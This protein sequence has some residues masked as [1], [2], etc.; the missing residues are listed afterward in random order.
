M[1]KK[2]LD[3]YLRLVYPI[4]AFRKG[5]EWAVWHT[6]FGRSAVA[7]YGKT[8]A[9]AV[10]MLNRDRRFFIRHL[11]EHNVDIPEPESDPYEEYSG[12]FVLRIPKEL[13]FRLAREAKRRGVSM[14]AHLKDL[15][16]ERDALDRRN[17]LECIFRSRTDD[18]A[19]IVREIHLEWIG[20]REDSTGKLQLDGADPFSQQEA[21]DQRQDLAK[22][23]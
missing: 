7:G 14:N 8:Q 11:Y 1:N 19:P 15:L 23:G 22:A 6:E 16:S 5:S 4:V 13:H 17:E 21:Q 10:R 18:L 3:H 2:S 9:A 20:C 12:K